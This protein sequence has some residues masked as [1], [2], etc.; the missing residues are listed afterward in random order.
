MDHM[1]HSGKTSQTVYI[2][3]TIDVLQ[4]DHILVKVIDLNI[5]YLNCID[6]YLSNFYSD[7]AVDTSK[8]IFQDDNFF[9]RTYS[10]HD[11]NTILDNH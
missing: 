6:C 11:W 10:C 1:L 5:V 7:T 9:K 2:L 4:W 3:E 8:R